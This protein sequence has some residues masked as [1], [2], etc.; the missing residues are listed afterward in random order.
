MYQYRAAHCAIGEYL[1]WHGFI[2]VEAE[3]AQLSKDLLSA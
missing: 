1:F 3:I 2:P